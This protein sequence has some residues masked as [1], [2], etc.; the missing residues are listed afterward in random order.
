[1]KISEVTPIYNIVKIREFSSGDAILIEVRDKQI[2]L[3]HSFAHD[4]ILVKE[5]VEGKDIRELDIITKI[6]L[7]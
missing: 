1:M 2:I 5:I 7:G 4:A 6:P 3:E